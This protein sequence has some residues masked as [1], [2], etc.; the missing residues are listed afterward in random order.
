MNK[1]KEND[2]LYKKAIELWGEEAQLEMIVEE[3]AELI[4][5]IQKLKRNDGDRLPKL[6]KVHEEIA[7][8]RIVLEQAYYFFSRKTIDKFYNQKL[9]RLAHRVYKGD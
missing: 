4:H 9:T 5:A 7:D 6:E 8:V 2:D 3:C 1:I